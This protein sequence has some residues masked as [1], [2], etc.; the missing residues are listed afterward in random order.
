MSP[1][2]RPFVLD[3][4]PQRADE[5][6]DGAVIGEDAG[7]VGPPLDL[8][9]SAAP[10]APFSSLSCAQR[11]GRICRSTCVICYC[12]DFPMWPFAG[13]VARSRGQCR[14]GN[15]VENLCVLLRAQACRREWRRDLV[16][17]IVVMGV[18][19]CGKSTIAAAIGQARSIPFIDGDDLHSAEA[20]AKMQVGSPLTDADRAGWLDR[21]ADVLAT[22]PA[23]VLA[24]SALKRIYRD[25]LRAAA[26][27]IIF[28]HLDGDFDTFLARLEA[29]QGHYFRRPDMLRSQF[30]A[31]EPP[32]DEPD[33]VSIDA[34][35]SP[36]EV[37]AACLS[38]LDTLRRN[39]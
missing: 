15:A 19:G 38:R 12:A 35:R 11:K 6:T 9:V 24:C 2:V 37:L 33:A 21:L 4:Q 3:F 26:P 32:D 28:L 36:D 27:G 22:N 23:I 34:T 8:P 10:T 13:I 1:R 30:D 7:D 20:R 31:L 16:E 39:P 5:L 25:R 17:R 29:R 14:R 18:A